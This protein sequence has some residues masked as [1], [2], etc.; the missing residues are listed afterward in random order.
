MLQSCSKRN[1]IQS[2]ADKLL[3]QKNVAVDMDSSINSFAQLC[4]VDTLK[5]DLLD[6][7]VNVCFAVLC[8][9]FMGIAAWSV[10][11]SS[12]WCA[13]LGGV[14]RLCLRFCGVVGCGRF[15]LLDVVERGRGGDCCLGFEMHTNGNVVEVVAPKY[16]EVDVVDN[17]EVIVN[18]SAK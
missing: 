12:R 4:D 9:T 14:A 6:R 1:G 15:G 8:V 5:S 10:I 3:L 17:V 11:T 16:K 13:L 7:L 2:L 18:K